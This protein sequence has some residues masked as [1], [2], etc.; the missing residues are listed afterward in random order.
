MI[1]FFEAAMFHHLEY[2]FV[3]HSSGYASG[4]ASEIFI[5]IGK[6]KAWCFLGAFSYR[7]V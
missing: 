3:W 6:V 7:F 4:I 5:D 2:K 1:S